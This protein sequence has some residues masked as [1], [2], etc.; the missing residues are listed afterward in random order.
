VAEGEAV[1]RAAGV[2]VAGWD[3]DAQRRSDGPT[4]RRVGGE[5]REGGSTW[6]SLARGAAS[7]ETDD[8]NGEI[9]LQARLAG[10]DAPVN[11][12]LQRLGHEMVARRV[13]PGAY[14]E[15]QLV[16]RLSA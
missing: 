11:E 16:A 15:E 3:E 8:L 5:L 12:M 6:Q 2:D 10:V 4:M 14:T 13:G 9:V 1:L 7:L